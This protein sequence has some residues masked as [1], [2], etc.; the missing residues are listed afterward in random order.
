MF[1]GLVP[2]LSFISENQEHNFME[3]VGRFR[4][5]VIRVWV[6]NICDSLYCMTFIV[7]I[8]G[9]WLNLSHNN[10]SRTLSI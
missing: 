8:H 7:P 1:N 4:A 3:N 2:M 6:L 5:L 9:K 10:V